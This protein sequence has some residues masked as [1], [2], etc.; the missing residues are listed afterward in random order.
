MRKSKGANATT[1]QAVQFQG[2]ITN[3]SIVCNNDPF[4]F[5]GDSQP[6]FVLGILRKVIIVSLDTEARSS[7]GLRDNFLSDGPV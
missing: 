2:A 7:Q 3:L 4:T 6:F 5:A 1:L